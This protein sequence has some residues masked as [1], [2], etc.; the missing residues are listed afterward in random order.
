L[1]RRTFCLRNIHGLIDNRGNPADHQI[2]VFPEADWNHRLDVQN[3][4]RAIARTD[5]EVPVLLDGNA[6]EA[7]DRVLRGL[8][9]IW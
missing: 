9:P 2:P 8:I 3:V 1:N 7:G 6:D 4:L 5:A